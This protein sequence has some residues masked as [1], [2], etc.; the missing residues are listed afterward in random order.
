MLAQNAGTL[1]VADQTSPATNLTGDPRGTFAP[2]GAASNG[3]NRLIIVQH[4]DG[5]QCSGT[6]TRVNAIGVTPA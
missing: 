1:V 4:V 2:S 6:A 3:S 5:T